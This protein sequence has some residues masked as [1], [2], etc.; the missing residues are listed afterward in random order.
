MQR[1][2]SIGSD[3]KASIFSGR[4]RELY[5]TCLGKA[6]AF[7]NWFSWPLLPDSTWDTWVRELMDVT[8][9][10]AKVPGRTQVTVLVGGRWR[11]DSSLVAGIQLKNL[12]L[13]SAALSC[14]TPAQVS[15]LICL[16]LLDGVPW[17][18]FWDPMCLTF[19]Q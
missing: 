18:P 9:L 4:F 8:T 3:S 6:L 16:R 2:T 13:V 12:K 11:L 15:R 5:C 17:L 1:S 7:Y 14:S 19:L 10:A